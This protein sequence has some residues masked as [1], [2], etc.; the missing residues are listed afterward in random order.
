MFSLQQKCSIDKSQLLQ[1]AVSIDAEA[2]HPSFS[3][4]QPQCTPTHIPQ[5]LIQRQCLLPVPLIL[6]VFCRCSGSFGSC[7]GGAGQQ[8]GA[9]AAP[10]GQPGQRSAQ[11]STAGQLAARAAPPHCPG[12]Q[13]LHTGPAALPQGAPYS[14]AY[15]ATC[16]VHGIWHTVNAVT[17]CCVRM[18]VP[19][20][21]YHMLC[22]TCYTTCYTTCCLPHAGCH[23]P[24]GT[25]IAPQW[26]AHLTRCQKVLHMRFLMHDCMCRLSE[27]K[28]S[29]ACQAAD[30]YPIV[31]LYIY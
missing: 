20:A 9:A 31:C 14:A 7:A 6:S 29:N 25:C 28:E 16:S 2:E 24:C 13:C 18:C 11:R 10:A 8:R 4:V 19:H 17:T 27:R 21:L 26:P 15:S 1:C 12:P 23:I 5:L 3:A 30:L 22:T